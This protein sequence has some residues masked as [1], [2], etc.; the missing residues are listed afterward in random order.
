MDYKNKK[1]LV[2][3]SA[4]VEH[5]VKIN[6]KYEWK[7]NGFIDFE[8]KVDVTFMMRAEETCLDEVLSQLVKKHNT[9][10]LRYTYQDYELVF[11][12]PI[13]L[14]G[15]VIKSYKEAIN[16]ISNDIKKGIYK[17]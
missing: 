10:D 9:D 5:R 13:K 6:D 16:Q 1:H 15:D 8:T 2:R 14:K 12:F 17:K 4:L 7:S 11:H 3:C